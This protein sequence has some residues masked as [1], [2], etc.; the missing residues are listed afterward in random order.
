MN[1]PIEFE[2]GEILP[3]AMVQQWL[4]AAG[5]G[6]KIYRGCRVYPPDRVS[7]GDYS[8]IDE[9]VRIFAGE[10]VVIGRHVHLAFGC[11]I[12]GGGRCVIHDF[13]GIGAGVRLITGSELS[14]GRG[15]T[16][17]TIPDELRA[18]KRS[19]V[20]VG[21]HAVVFTNSVVFPGVKIGEGA[22]VAAGSL[23]H[24]DLNEWGIYAGQPL[25]QIGTRPKEVILKQA[26]ELI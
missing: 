20:E 22:V 17:P 24:H 14:D 6:I 5:K 11:S 25:I 12:S 2:A 16:N 1:R 4:K 10:E 23:V 26:G 8:Q 18:V 9:G 15:L 19:F 13:A 7:I 3:A 21:A